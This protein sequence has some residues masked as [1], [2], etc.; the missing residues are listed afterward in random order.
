VI[1]FP[2][3]RPTF[4]HSHVTEARSTSSLYILL[5]VH[6]V[7]ILGKWSTWRTVL[8]MYL[9]LFLTLHVLST[10]CSSSGET[11]CVNTTSGNCHS[12]SV[13]VSCA[14]RKWTSDLHTTRPLTQSGAFNQRDAQLF[15]V[16]LFLFLF[17]T[18]YMFRA[19]HAHHQ[20]RQ[21]VSTH[22]LLIFTVCRG[23]CRVQVG[24]SVVL[25]MHGELR[26]LFWNVRNSVNY[27]GDAGWCGSW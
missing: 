16:Y 5:T 23:P 10:L 20:E 7:M 6:H 27:D 19:H 1:S 3:C 11:N 18:L 2:S 15:T 4:K 26:W 12:V 14:G 9:F 8:I 22:T 17:L 13:S 24:S 21:I 25:H